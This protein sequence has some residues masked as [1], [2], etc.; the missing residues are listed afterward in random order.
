MV[1]IEKVLG[2]GKKGWY[3]NIFCDSSWELAFVLYHKDNN[4]DIQR[5][6]EVRTYQFEGQ[7]K[8]YYPDFIVGNQLYEIKGYIT[9]QSEAKQLYNPDIKL[10]A[11]EAMKQYLDYA[12][13]QYGKNYTDL[14]E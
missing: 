12:V 4:L 5:C 7:L 10:L 13:S 11:K 1:V 8:N 2:R 3:K 9:P 14:Y 6:V